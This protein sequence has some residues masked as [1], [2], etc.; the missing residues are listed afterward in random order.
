MLPSLSEGFVTASQPIMSEGTGELTASALL[1]PSVPGA[2]V[3]PPNA[4]TRPGSEPGTAAGAQPEGRGP[5]R[6][7]VLAAGSGVGTD[8]EGAGAEGTHGH[9]ERGTLGPKR[10]RLRAAKG[11]LPPRGQADPS[12]RNWGRWRQTTAVRTHPVRREKTG[13]RCQPGRPGARQAPRHRTRAALRGSAA[14][15]GLRVPIE[16][17]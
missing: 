15:R 14:K 9:G 7:A 11:R 12:K 6:G 13:E 2:P 1:P 17:P 5:G 16:L 10:L 8:P 4:P 3:P